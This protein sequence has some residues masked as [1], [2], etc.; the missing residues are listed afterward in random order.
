MSSSHQKFY[1]ISLHFDEESSNTDILDLTDMLG[2]AFKDENLVGDN[3]F[4]CNSCGE[5]SCTY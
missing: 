5:I 3:Q 4:Y 1:D 2:K